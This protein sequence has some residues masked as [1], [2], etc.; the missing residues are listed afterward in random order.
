MFPK[1]TDHNF[2]GAETS[3]QE[4]ELNLRIDKFSDEG[5]HC[6][7]RRLCHTLVFGFV[8][9]LNRYCSLS[10]AHK[11]LIILYGVACLSDYCTCCTIKPYSSGDVAN[12]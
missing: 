7:E 10:N 5:L 2:A 12:L 4:V 9:L 8:Y 3:L 1:G 6:K 11:G